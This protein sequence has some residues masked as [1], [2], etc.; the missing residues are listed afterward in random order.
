MSLIIDDLL[1]RKL[2]RTYSLPDKPIGKISQQCNSRLRRCSNLDLYFK[3][4]LKLYSVPCV[5]QTYFA[6]CF[7]ILDHATDPP[8]PGGKALWKWEIH[9]KGEGKVGMLFKHAEGVAST[10]RSR[11]FLSTTLSESNGKNLHFL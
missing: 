10:S 7:A 11:N 5:N 1:H 3:V 4:R 9:T 2:I 6:D 8:Q